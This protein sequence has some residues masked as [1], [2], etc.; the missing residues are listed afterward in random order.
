MQYHVRVERDYLAV[1]VSQSETPVEARELLYAI[2]EPVFK[3]GRKPILISAMGGSPL[4]LVDLYSLAQ[5]VIDTPLRHCKIGF[6]YQ[7]ECEL[8]ASHFIEE[9][10]EGRGV[11]ISV[12]G[13]IPE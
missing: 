2:T 9:L 1:E 12:L 11:D 4:A 10:A 8:E 6:L 5:H 3:H 7:G 13:T